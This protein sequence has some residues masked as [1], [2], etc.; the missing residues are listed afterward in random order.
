MKFSKHI[1][2]I[3][4]RAVHMRANLIH[5]CF[6]SRDALTR[7]FIVYVRPMLAYGSC[8]GLHTSTSSDVD[9]SESVQRRFTKRLRFYNNTNNT[10][11]VAQLK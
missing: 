10:Y 1:G 4:A 2:N 7:A 3:A 6:L 5:K 11:R 8:I 9:R